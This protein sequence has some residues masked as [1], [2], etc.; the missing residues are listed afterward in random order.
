[1]GH[2]MIDLETLKSLVHLMAENDLSELDIRDGDETV[3]LKRGAAEQVIAQAASAP[4]PPPAQGAPPAA[5]AVQEAPAVTEP[6]E[7]DSLVAVESPMVGTYFDTPNPD[8][9]PFVKVGD[10]VT[11]DT[12]VCLIEAMKVFTEVK[13]ECA[14][15]IE[16]ILV[17][18]G[19]PVEFGQRLLL[20]KPA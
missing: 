14:G 18:S 20:I 10:K 5:P 2:Q 16:K 3:R 11:E 1:M 6:A 7:D 15:V 19:D 12:V 4:A 17:K 8:S 9:P 13:A